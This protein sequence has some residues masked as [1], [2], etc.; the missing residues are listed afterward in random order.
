[1]ANKTHIPSK[2]FETREI[3]LSGTLI[4]DRINSFEFIR[5]SRIEMERLKDTKEFQEALHEYSFILKRIV[6]DEMIEKMEGAINNIQ[7]FM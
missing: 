6:Q 3:N 4:S 7:T 5:E 2:F 1:M